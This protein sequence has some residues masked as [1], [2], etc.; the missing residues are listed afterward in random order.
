MP[1]SLLALFPLSAL[2]MHPLITRAPA[3]IAEGSGSTVTNIFFDSFVSSSLEIVSRIPAILVSTVKLVDGVVVV[4]DV[5]A[6]PVCGQACAESA[7]VPTMGCDS[8]ANL[9]TAAVGGCN[10]DSDEF[11]R[12]PEGE[13]VLLSCPLFCSAELDARGSC[14]LARAQGVATKPA[15]VANIAHA[16]TKTECFFMTTS[17]H[18][19]DLLQLR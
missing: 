11:D 8:T 3:W 14:E 17:K 16:K 13:G 4:A 18:T 15:V 10:L 6:E 19:F 9:S 2:V 7:D 1:I 12:A 5:A